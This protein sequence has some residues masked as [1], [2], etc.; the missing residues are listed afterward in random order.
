M[1]RFN[2]IKNYQSIKVKLAN[3]GEIIGKYYGR[4]YNKVS[5]NFMLGIYTNSEDNILA[6]G[7]IDVNKLCQTENTNILEITNTKLEKSKSDYYFTTIKNLKRVD[8]ITAGDKVRV[9]STRKQDIER[10]LGRKLRKNE[11]FVVKNVYTLYGERLCSIESED[12]Q[13]LESIREDTVY[14]I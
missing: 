7:V 13:I 2:N 8:N 3:G 11:L 12:N 5:S 1:S 14:K 4:T 9:F 6:K 10:Y